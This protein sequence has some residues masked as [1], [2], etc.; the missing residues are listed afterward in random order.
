MLYLF[1]HNYKRYGETQPLDILDMAKANIILSSKITTR[2][3]QNQQVENDFNSLLMPQSSGQPTITRHKGTVEQIASIEE[4]WK[5][6]KQAI[7]NCATDLSIV[8]EQIDVL[9][10]ELDTLMNIVEGLGE[11]TTTSVQKIKEARSALE[12][13]KTM[14]YWEEATKD[15]TNIPK[16]IK[17]KIGGVL[18]SATGYA[19]EIAVAVGLA[20]SDALV[21]YKIVNEGGKSGGSIK[22][23]ID[24]RLK[25]KASEKDKHD[26]VMQKN[27]I[28]IAVS[29]TNVNITILSPGLSIKHSPSKGTTRVHV[30]STTLYAMLMKAYNN[31]EG[32]IN[33]AAGLGADSP[34]AAS[35]NKEPNFSYT[36]ASL[37][38][39]WRQAIKTAAIQQLV[40]WIAGTGVVG[41]N[42]Q[43]LVINGRIYAVRDILTYIK[44]NINGSRD[45]TKIPGVRYD[46][47]LNYQRRPFVQANIDSFVKSNH[48]DS[49]ADEVSA[50]DKKASAS[51]YSKLSQQRVG[52]SLTL[53]KMG[54][55]K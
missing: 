40:D 31:E 36:T 18:S 42:V 8:V 46:D 23:N 12:L 10:K 3:E 15:A 49:L 38:K 1:Y 21:A 47:K 5:I 9:C 51:V 24:D 39:D 20:Q 52:L 26:T 13:M 17:S 2:L 6:A 48:D 54:L 29:D 25:E 35:L 44:N 50:R 27:D 45:I 30:H 34:Q 33:L 28:T 32:I 37:L 16:L 4:A 43:Y 7:N 53:S 55:T 22:Y 14:K 41:D 19:E 11:V